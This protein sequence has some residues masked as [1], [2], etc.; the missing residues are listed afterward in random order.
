MTISNVVYAKSYDKNC[1]RAHIQESISINSDRKKVYAQITDGASNRIFNT[2]IAY[3]VA[4]LIPAALFDLKA[5]SYQKKGVPLFCHEFMSMNRA[6]DFD[7]E[8]R[9]I[10]EEPFYSFDWKFYLIRIENALKTKKLE[11]VKKISLEAI[12]A[13][14][15]YP[16]Y[17]CMT[18]HLFESIYRF[19]HFTPI[20]EQQAK[21]R[22]L[23]DPTTININVMKLHLLGFSQTYNIDLWAQPIQESGIPIL[24]SEVPNLLFDI[25]DINELKR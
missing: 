24:C 12:K 2:L 6:P 8:V 5:S 14:N 3:E 4:T 18:R 20:R 13:L 19:A 9:V 11:D 25:I 21:E 16:H 15:A 23:K 7:P 22:G 17:Y 10:P 1:F